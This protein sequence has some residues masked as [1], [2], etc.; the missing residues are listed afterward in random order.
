MLTETQ[1]R[2]MMPNA[3]ARLDAHLPFINPA[4][5]EG[6]I[7]TPKR[8]AAFLAQ[9]AHESGEYRYME[10]LADGSAYEGRIDLGNMRPGDGVKYKGHGPIQITGRDNHRDCGAALGLDLI[11]DPLL[12]TTPEHGT[13]AAVWFWNSRNLSLL[14]DRDWFKTITLRIN[15]GLNGFSDRR[16]Y[17]DRMRSLLGLPLVDTGNEAADI[18]AFQRSRGLAADGVVGPMTMRA[19]AA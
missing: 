18:M 6:G 4:M 17:W 15:G 8:I 3:G 14:A 5:E 19:L 16:Q 9:L 2:R 13:R 12:I 7:T 1:I 11:A 10:E